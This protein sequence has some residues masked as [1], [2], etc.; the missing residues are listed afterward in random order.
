MRDS[1]KLMDAIGY[2]AD[3][4]VE[5]T[6]EK[7][8]LLGRTRGQVRRMH[9]MRRALS[10]AAVVALLLSL[11]AGAFA[12]GWAIWSHSL[13]S[14]LDGMTEEGRQAV[15]QSGLLQS[16]RIAADE[17]VGVAISVVQTLTDGS[18][19]R[20]ALQIDGLDW[21][22]DCNQVYTDFELRVDGKETNGNICVI[23]DGY[24]DDR[25][26]GSHIEAILT[27]EDYMGGEIELI[28]R[29]ITYSVWHAGMTEEEYKQQ[30]PQGLARGKWRLVWTP[31]RNAEAKLVMLDM[32]FCRPGADEVVQIPVVCRIG[33]MGVRVYGIV[34]E[35]VQKKD[36]KEDTAL[37]LDSNLVPCGVLEAGGSRKSIDWESG[38]GELNP[39][40]AFSLCYLLKGIIPLDSVEGLLFA[41]GSEGE[42]PIACPFREFDEQDPCVQEL[43]SRGFD[44]V[45]NA[46]DQNN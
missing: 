12:I 27:I 35:D 37:V 46:G 43:L 10:V 44:F 29:K 14:Y 28:I 31:S 6:G 23:G 1:E 32:P 39:D 8:G 13:D 9:M 36:G 21:P 22:E 20:A 26:T 33:M 30:T 11:G 38:T 4:E 40:G 34:P 45:E 24:A 25:Q 16:G 17:S 18:S 41:A 2:L 7:L 42:E 19:T 3:D 15:E 5:R